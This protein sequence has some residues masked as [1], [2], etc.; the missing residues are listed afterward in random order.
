MVY[1][2]PRST[3]SHCGSLKAL[4]HRVPV[5]PS[6]ALPAAVPAF[7]A[8]D[9]VA[10]FPWDSSDVAAVAELVTATTALAAASPTLGN[11]SLTPTTGT[12][13]LNAAAGAEPDVVAAAAALKASGAVL[14]RTFTVRYAAYE[15]DIVG[16]VA[17]VPS[18]YT[19][20]EIMDRFAQAWNG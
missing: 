3:D 10:G 2:A 6:T 4:D 1:V 13:E 19:G 5:L 12:I 11:V 18:G 20:G 14:S 7:S 15:A 8:D 9:A 17:T 16:G